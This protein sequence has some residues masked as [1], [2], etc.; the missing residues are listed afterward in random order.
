MMCSPTP[1]EKRL[2]FKQGSPSRLQNEREQKRLRRKQSN[3]ESA[4]RSRLRKQ[5]E[6]KA[7]AGRVTDLEQN[8]ARLVE[9]NKQLNRTLTL[10]SEKYDE[11]RP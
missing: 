6:C 10:L 5:A 8:N 3:R 2:E 4:R 1:N 7:L 11:A 9:E